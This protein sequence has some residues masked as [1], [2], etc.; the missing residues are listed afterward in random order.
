MATSSVTK[1]FIIKD[2]RIFEQIMK[3]ISKV[4]PLSKRNIK[5]PEENS[6]YRGKELLKQ[7]PFF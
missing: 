7:H 3:D 4:T 1:D 5:S 2:P 6:I